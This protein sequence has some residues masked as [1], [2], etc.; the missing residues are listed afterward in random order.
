MRNEYDDIAVILGCK[1]IPGQP[2]HYLCTCHTKPEDLQCKTWKSRELRLR[3]LE[4]TCV[5]S[6]KTARQGKRVEVTIRIEWKRGYSP[7][8]GDVYDEDDLSL[9]FRKIE[10]FRSRQIS[11]QV[12]EGGHN[13]ALGTWGWTSNQCGSDEMTEGWKHT[14]SSNWHLTQIS[15]P[16]T[17]S[18]SIDLTPAATSARCV[19]LA[20]M[21]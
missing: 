19:R 1:E 10:S 12:V 18:M 16:P 2:T 4:Q 6:G 13:V 21:G 20:C 8:W 5:L 11:F 15:G 17:I 7:F 9:E 14:L 3:W